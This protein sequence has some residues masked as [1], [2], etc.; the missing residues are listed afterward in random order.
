MS[1]CRSRVQSKTHAGV[2][3]AIAVLRGRSGGLLF[4][5]AVFTGSRSRSR[6]HRMSRRSDCLFVDVAARCGSPVVPLSGF[7]YSGV[8]YFFFIRLCL[9]PIALRISICWLSIHARL[10]LVLCHGLLDLSVKS[11]RSA[12]GPARVGRQ[13]WK[14]TS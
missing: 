2:G 8:F 5:P 7:E 6:S 10:A 11:K 4:L 3:L 12:C 9:F 14:I 1:E 13:H